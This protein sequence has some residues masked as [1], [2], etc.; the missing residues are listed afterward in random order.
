MIIS[1]IVAASDNHVIGKDGKLPWDLPDDLKRFRQLTE[2]KPVIMGRK[3]FESIGHALPRRQNIIISRTLKSPPA[4]CE[5]YA[6]L[7]DALAQ[8]LGTNKE[9]FIIGGGE[10]F[11]QISV[12]AGYSVDRIYLTRVHTIIQGGDVY[13]PEID[14]TEW[15]E[16]RREEHAQDSEHPFPYLHRL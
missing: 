2:G 3:T 6:S 12:L 14:P 5:I 11:H 9:V 7:P 1:L 4:G 8:F 15:Q 13:F 10:I 16:V